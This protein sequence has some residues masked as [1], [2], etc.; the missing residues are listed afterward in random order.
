[1]DAESISDDDTATDAASEAFD[2]GVR[3][4]G[5]RRLAE[6]VEL[7][8]SAM[9]RMADADYHSEDLVDDWFT[10]WGKCVRDSTAVA[11][12]SWQA[13]TDATTRWRRIGRRR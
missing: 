6:Y 3:S 4:R 2:G 8:E 10:W 12:L 13:Y 7:W 11:A 1:M 9:S 5:R